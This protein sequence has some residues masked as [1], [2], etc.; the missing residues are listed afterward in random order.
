MGLV[1]PEDCCVSSDKHER[2]AS[3]LT[4]INARMM[5]ALPNTVLILG[6]G[7]GAFVRNSAGNAD[8]LGEFLEYVSQQPRH[9]L[10]YVAEQRLLGKMEERKRCVCIIIY[11]AGI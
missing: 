6:D 8:L 3:V 2:I 5:K 4:L 11:D 10:A 1:N 7:Y 9:T